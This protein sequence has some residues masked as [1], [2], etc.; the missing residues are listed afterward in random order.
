MSSLINLIFYFQAK[1]SAKRFDLNETK[2]AKRLFNRVNKMLNRVD[3]LVTTL[4][5]VN[6]LMAFLLK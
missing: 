1:E 6:I 3:L 4:E 2:G 5:K